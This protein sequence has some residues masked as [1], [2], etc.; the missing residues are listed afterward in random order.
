MYAKHGNFF[1]LVSLI[2]ISIIIYRHCSLF[3]CGIRKW[4][5]WL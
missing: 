4:T 1:T 5:L 2:S 3:I